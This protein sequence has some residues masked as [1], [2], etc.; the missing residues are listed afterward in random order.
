MRGPSLLGEEDEVEEEDT[1][2]TELLAATGK[3]EVM[4][5][6]EA[7]DLEDT[8]TMTETGEEDVV[9]EEEA[10]METV[11]TT[12]EE[13]VAT[14]SEV[15]EVPTT[16]EMTTIEVVADIE[17]GATLGEMTTKKAE[18]EEGT[19]MEVDG[20][21]EN[22]NTDL[23]SDLISEEVDSEMID[24]EEMVEDSSEETVVP[25]KT[26]TTVLQEMGMEE[27]SSEVVEDKPMM[28][29]G[30][31]V[32]KRA[33]G[34]TPRMMNGTRMI[35]KKNRTKRMKLPPKSQSK[36]DQP[37][38]FEGVAKEPMNPKGETSAIVMTTG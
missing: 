30:L 20:H 37:D 11:T 2:E 25:I 21:A 26:G 6:S 10:M 33:N 34:Q 12:T 22:S 4:E 38:N 17:E 13:E 27:V 29:I 9:E 15:T 1:T 14:A 28:M 35:P 32:A 5:I 18:Q 3:D 23:N 16:E 36:K 7:E 24:L 8:T 19:V 31:E